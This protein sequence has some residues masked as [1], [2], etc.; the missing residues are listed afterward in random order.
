MNIKINI[1]KV[2][3]IMLVALIFIQQIPFSVVNAKAAGVQAAYRI[4]YYTDPFKTSHFSHFIID[5]TN[6]TELPEYVIEAAED[7][8]TSATRRNDWETLTKTDML[9]PGEIHR[10]VQDDLW[11]RYESS[12]TLN[13]GELPI[14]YD[15]TIST[16]SVKIGGQNVNVPT[17]ST[18][19][20]RADIYRNNASNTGLWEVKPPSYWTTNKQKGILQLAGYVYFGVDSNGNHSYQFG[21]VSNPNII[22]GGSF[23]FNAYYACSDITGA[24]VWGEVVTYIVDYSVTSDSLIIYN[25]KRKPP[26]DSDPTLNP[27]LGPLFKLAIDKLKDMMKN[28][29]PGGL[30]NPNPQPGY[31]FGYEPAYEPDYEPSP[32]PDP[33]PDSNPHYVDKEEGERTNRLIE[34]LRNPA[35]IGIRDTLIVAAIIGVV[36]LLS[37]M[38]TSEVII[39]LETGTLSCEEAM[40]WFILPAFEK[41]GYADELTRYVYGDTEED[42]EDEEL[43]EDIHDES[44]DYDDAGD[45]APPRDPLAIDFGSNGIDLT[46]LDNGVNFDLDN[47]GFSEKTAWIGTEDGFLALDVN[48]N[49]KIDNGSELFGDQFIR[50][51]GKRSESGFEALSDFDEDDDKMITENDTV[52]GNLLIW[53][54]DNHNGNSESNELFTLTEKNIQAISINYT[55]SN[56]RDIPTGTYVAETANVIL[57]NGKTSISEFWFDVDTTNTTQNGTVTS[58]NVPSIMEAIYEDETGETAQLYLDFLLADD[59]VIRRYYLKKLLYKITNSENIS[60]DSRGGNIDARDLHMVEQFMGR[61]FIGV[62]GENPNAPAAAI[63][64]KICNRIENIYYCILISQT[65]FNIQRQKMVIDPDTNSIDITVLTNDIKRMIDCGDSRAKQLIYDLGVYLRVYDRRSNTHH[66]DDY[67]T[68]CN[69]LSQKYAAISVI[70][71]SEAYTFI[72]TNDANNFKG[73]SSVNYLFGQNG[74]DTLTGDNGN[75]VIY[76]GNGND[77]LIGGKGNDTYVIEAG[78]GNDIICDNQGTNLIMFADYYTEN[79]FTLSVDAKLGLVIT[80][81]ETGENISIPDFITN[82]FAYKFSYGS[83]EASFSI[84]NSEVYNGTN[85]DDVIESDDGFNIFYAGE[86]KDTIAGGDNIDFMYGGNG[87]DTLLGRNGTNIIYGE[88]GNDIIRDGDD[89]SF[90]SGGADNDEIYGGGGADILDGGAGNDLLQGDHGNDTFI[91]GIGYDIDTLTDAAGEPNTIII[92]GY[93]KS[94][95]NNFRDG[96]NL[97]IDFGKNTGDRMIIE[98]FFDYAENSDITFIFDDGTSLSRFDIRAKSMPIYGD[99]NNNYINGTNEADIIDGGAGDDTLCGFDGEDTYVFGRNYGHDIINEWGSDHSFV[100]FKNINSDEISITGSTNTPIIITVNDTEDTLTFATSFWAS[101]T[102]TL[103]FADGAEGYVD[104]NTY[105]FIFTKQPDPVDE[106]NITDSDI[107]EAEDVSDEETAV[108][109]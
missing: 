14:N 96:S 22:S 77:I 45:A 56:F 39:A 74:D 81:K 100:E 47:N 13:G 50:L 91:Y 27:I 75:D 107:S 38:K 69:T 59:F 25:F 86:G 82:P 93:R 17:P 55:E 19:S 106:E 16:P 26:I 11:Y 60:H 29:N 7:A 51:N 12:G 73:F 97:I 72:G 67:Q 20:G 78:H 6:V 10:R 49:G 30:G 89:S 46:T 57:N 34:A 52:F 21:E 85:E 15:K 31:A 1:H 32:D 43:T 108:A 80:N 62:D 104:K 63:L 87:D 101:A 99:E 66:F 48:G 42:N 95:M 92:H 35:V 2:V 24:I 33:T 36:E 44:D 65:E 83:K 53:I 5:T 4:L 79:D 3:S 40:C 68:F 61:T 64:N 94:D 88:G 76:G 8:K 71:G 102:Y 98:R 54:D 109:A 103:I 37:S 18:L 9:S 58:G 70:A 84:G 41:H 90:L 105:E 28:K 23:E